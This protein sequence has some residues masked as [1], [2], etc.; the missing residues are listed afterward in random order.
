MVNV[1]DFE[2]DIQTAIS[3]PRIIL[4]GF[5]ET[6]SEIRPVLDVE[7]RIPPDVR[8]ELSTRGFIINIVAEDEGRVNGIMRDPTSGFLLGGADPRGETYAIGW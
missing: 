8:R 2:M 3:K 5:Q 1:L 4:G 7:E 6:G